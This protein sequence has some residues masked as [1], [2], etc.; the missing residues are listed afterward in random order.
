PYTRA[1]IEQVAPSAPVIHFGTDTDGLLEAMSEAGGDV[2]GIDWRI[3]LDHA[4][5]RIGDRAI[6]GNLDPTVLL[7][8]VATLR[9]EARAILGQAQGRAG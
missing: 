3:R 6:M 4:W 7:A 2:I 9:Q 5:Q 1:V 8:D